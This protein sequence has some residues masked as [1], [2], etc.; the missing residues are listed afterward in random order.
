MQRLHTLFFPVPVQNITKKL[1]IKNPELLYSKSIK[2][3]LVFLRPERKSLFDIARHLQRN[4][5]DVGFHK[6]CDMRNIVASVN[7]LRHL[8]VGQKKLSSKNISLI[9]HTIQGHIKYLKLSKS[10]FGSHFLLV[11][12]MVPQLVSDDD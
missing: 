1:R 5:I 6:T 3:I 7:I 11:Q 10:P 2:F 12:K 4:E 9:L 8:V